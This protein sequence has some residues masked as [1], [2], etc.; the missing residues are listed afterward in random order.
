MKNVIR[1]HSPVLRNAKD[2]QLFTF[3]EHLF[4]NFCINVKYLR[5]VYSFSFRFFLCGYNL[6]RWHRTCIDFSLYSSALGWNTKQIHVLKKVHVLKKTCSLLGEWHLS[7]ITINQ[8]TLTTHSHYWQSYSDIVYIHMNRISFLL[9]C[10][11]TA[12]NSKCTQY[13]RVG[14]VKAIIISLFFGVYWECSK[15]FIQ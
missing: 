7:C 13:I 4:L 10:S 9:K 11:T 12:A 8:R 5:P 15:T 2:Y 6:N 1:C 3:I 14:H